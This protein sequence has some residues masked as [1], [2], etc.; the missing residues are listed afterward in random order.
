MAFEPLQTDEKLDV[1][2]QT[3]QDM[4]KQMLFGCSGFLIASVVGYLLT[5]WPFLAFQ[6][7]EQTFWLAACFAAGGGPAIIVGLISTRRFGL[8]GACG[9]VA[10]AMTTGIFLYLRIQQ[11]FLSALAKSSPTPEYPDSFIWL[12]P[13]VWILLCVFLAVVALPKGEIS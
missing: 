1:P 12:L 7:I 2:E 13:I 10:G 5:I 4:D 6:K 11:S 8:A 9:F 3:A